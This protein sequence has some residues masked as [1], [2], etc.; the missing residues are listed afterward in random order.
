MK[1]KSEEMLDLNEENVKNI[2]NYCL[3]KKDTKD[4]IKAEFLEGAPNAQLPNIFFSK[5]K[6]LEKNHTITY[7]LGQL[8]DV[9]LKSH[10]IS[11]LD[12]FNK[13][14]GTTWTNN[15]G[16]LFMLYYLGTIA[17]M[18]PTFQ[19]FKPKKTY[20]SIILG[21]SFLKPTLSPNDP[22]FKK[23]TDGQEPADD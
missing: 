11:L 14:D 3:A 1:F 4:P 19:L 12:G 18:L 23:K 7:L 15:K 9:H 8:N 17:T 5:E 20:V 21:N 10:H 2:F 13:Y 16:T 22:N 6:V